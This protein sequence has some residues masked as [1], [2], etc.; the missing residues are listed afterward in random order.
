LFQYNLAM[1][2]AYIML[3]IGWIAWFLPFPLNKW[4]FKS[5]AQ[6]DKRA[7]WG[8]L[9]Q[10]I[11][12]SLLWQTS[13]W[14]NAP[15][16]WRVALAAVFLALA[17][18]LSWTA[19]HS[20]GRHLRLDAAVNPDHQLVSSGAY[21]WIRH[22]IYT[23]MFCVLLGTGLLLTPLPLLLVSV[24][25]FV[26]GTEIRVRIEDALLETHFGESFREYRRSVRA[27]VPFIR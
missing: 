12:Y 21:A 6:Q 22:P 1:M 26:A 23:S 17:P 2:L 13:F 20:L 3:A 10:L 19:V 8:I 15:G 14:K 4:N 27:Y 18:L 5:P 11:G 16:S 25:V 24:V 7:R 9:L